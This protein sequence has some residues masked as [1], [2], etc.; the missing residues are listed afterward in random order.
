MNKIGRVPT[1]KPNP[2]LRA[3]VAETESEH[4][5]LASISHLGWTQSDVLEYV[6]TPGTGVYRYK[7]SEE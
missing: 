5:A 4:I 1:K 2:E 3:I 7:Q 6:V